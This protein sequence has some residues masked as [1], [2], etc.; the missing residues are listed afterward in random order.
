M[1]NVTKIRAAYSE[2]AKT[3]AVKF[4]DE[5]TNFNEKMEINRHPIWKL[6]EEVKASVLFGNHWIGNAEQLVERRIFRHPDCVTPDGVYVPD[7]EV[8]LT[9]VMY[10]TAPR[11]LS[12]SLY[13]ETGTGKSE[14]ARFVSSL[15][16][17]PVKQLSFTIGTR[18]DKLMGC[19]QIKDGETFYQN[20][21]I[22]LAYDET[23]P[24]YIFIADEM[25]KANESV[26]SKLHDI[27]DGKPFTVED[28]GDV[29]L[30]HPN[31][32]FIATCQSNGQGDPSGRYNVQKLDRAFCARFMWK[33]TKY[34]SQEVMNSIL[35][36]SYPEA[37]FAFLKSVSAFY[38]LCVKALENGKNEDKGLSLTTILDGSDGIQRLDTPVSIRL[39]KGFVNFAVSTVGVFNPRKCFETSILQSAEESDVYALESLSKAAMGDLLENHL[40]LNS[41]VLQKKSLFKK[42]AKNKNQSS[43]ISDI[44]TLIVIESN[45]D[46]VSPLTSTLVVET[47]KTSVKTDNLGVQAEIDA[48]AE[49]DAQAEIDAKAELDAQAAID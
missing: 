45:K 36:A 31:F 30:P 22:P 29:F 49:L 37:P 3:L 25:D 20:G 35:T 33:E 47:V 48:K 4:N 13:G 44:D 11:V 40:V 38:N 27:T 21:V 24:G 34:P 14:M 32:R 6:T 26:I 23:G 28:T 16:N 9:T 18:E 8:L 19:H 12:L 5:S 1:T 15:L 43:L 17:I 39:I 46:V 10:I 41:A 42:A 2:I 7:P